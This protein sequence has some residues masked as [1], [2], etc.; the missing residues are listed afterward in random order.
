M[1]DQKSLFRGPLL[2]IRPINIQVGGGVMQASEMGTAILQDKREKRITLQSVLYVPGLGANLLSCR[3]LCRFGLQGSFTEDKLLFKDQSGKVVIQAPE[4]RGVYIVDSV[5]SSINEF[6][7]Y[8]SEPIPSQ[9]QAFEAQEEMIIDQDLQIPSEK[10][11][12]SQ[13]EYKLWH[14][15]FSHLGPGKIASLHKLTTLEKPI[16]VFK[17]HQCEICSVTKMRNKFGKT[18]TRK[19]DVLQLVSIDICGPFGPGHSGETQFLVIVDNFSR[20]TWIYGLKTRNQAPQILSQWKREAELESDAKLKAIRLD[21]AP[22][23]IQI[24]DQ[25]K[26]DYGVQSQPTVAYMSTQNGIAERANQTIE[27]G[28]RAMLKDSGLPNEFWL[29]AA[30]TDV[31]L[32]N[33]A[34]NGPT[35]DDV[36]VSPD[37][38]FTGVKP[39]IDHIRVWGCKVYSYMNPQSLPQDGRRDKLMDRARAGVFLGYV[40]G[41][42]KQWKIWAPDMRKVIKSNSLEFFENEQGSSIDLRIQ[43]KTTPNSAP[44]RKNVGRP[45]NK[46]PS[47]EPEVAQKESVQQ[48]EEQPQETEVP[49]EPPKPR[50]FVSHVEIQVPKRKREEEDDDD[51][52]QP[53]AKLQRSFLAQMLQIL[54][55]KDNPQEQ[56]WITLGHN[57][58]GKDDKSCQLTTFPIIEQGHASSQLGKPQIEI[59]TSYQKAIDDPTWGHLWKEAIDKEI[60]NLAANSTWEISTAP[61]GSN[62]I[63]S[64]WVF[65]VKYNTDGSIDKFKAR[66]VARGFSQKYGIDF[67]QTFAP[68][69]RHDTLRMFMAL[70]AIHDL[71]LHQ[72][73]VNNA[74]TESFLKEE[75]YMAPPP[76]VPTAPGQVLK[77]LRSLYGLKQAAR[78]WNQNCITTLQKIG[79]I[80]SDADPC[81]LIHPERKIII[82]VYVDDIPIGAPSMEQVNWFKSQFS[83]AF[84]IKDLGET[85][86]IL[87]VHVTRDRQTKTLRLDQTH[88]VHDIMSKYGM[89]KDKAQPVKIPLNG[90]ESI[91]PSGPNDLRTDQREYQQI[92]GSLLYLAILTRPDIAFAIGRLS[93]HLSDPSEHHMKALKGLMRYVRSTADLGI[94]YG[95]GINDQL[96]GYSDS[97]FAMDKT[98]RKS[99]LGNVFMLAGGPISW[100]S[101]KQ[102]SVATSTMDAEYMAMCSCAKQAQHL[103]H[104]LRYMGF[105]EHVGPNPFQPSVVEDFK[106]AYGSPVHLKGDNQAAISLV[107][108]AH[109][110]DRSKHIDVAYHYVRD[111]NR[112]KKIKV[113]F[114]GTADMIADGLTK[115]LQASLFQRFKVLLGLTKP[116]L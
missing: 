69:L 60:V 82:L 49:T 56:A 108:D 23:L 109:T 55:G 86:K 52:E 88:Y 5:S 3:K 81:L 104:L 30:E 54:Q 68:T 48:Q 74:F 22:E 83:K 16:Q 103:A 42:T 100:M 47:D 15:R 38:A 12:K 62:I 35:I 99:V 112:R 78:D 92:I 29:E 96:V 17:E 85:K 21:N 45:P 44:I 70:C 51:S 63:T 91:Q 87:G 14:R 114:L 6:S 24:T 73:D 115:P 32:R 89:E 71:E 18:S 13:E 25:W 90:Y 57:L 50:K 1:T 113:D 61:R 26:R 11:I 43:I 101:K 46:Q 93:Q 76:G 106:F 67:D 53:E 58:Y 40:K 28:M 84:K 34:S 37:E 64:R 8:S 98:D 97:D 95:A 19:N 39:S 107:Q 72:V 110:H 31:Y 33:L 116:D 2:K 4:F 65:A 111:L 59:P 77:V 102:K 36:Q 66:L 7:Y 105:E 41:T 79:F 9:A 94:T 80:Q 10:E 20:K 75:I 27:N